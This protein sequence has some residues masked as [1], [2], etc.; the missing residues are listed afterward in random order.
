MARAV[1]ANRCLNCDLPKQKEKTEWIYCRRLERVV[2][3]YHLS[4]NKDCPK[5]K[6]VY[7]GEEEQDDGLIEV[8]DM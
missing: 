1:K 6:A 7:H 8:S 5:A 4:L 2:H 3:I